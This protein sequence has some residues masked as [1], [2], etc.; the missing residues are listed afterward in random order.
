MV[1]RATG[2]YT[3]DEFSG[4]IRSVDVSRYG[5]VFVGSPSGNT[6]SELT[7]KKA[8]SLRNELNSNLLL[9][10]VLIPE[11]HAKKNEEHLRMLSKI[12]QGCSFFITQC[13]YNVDAAKDLLSDYHYECERQGVDK[14]PVI[15]T[16]TTCGSQQ[17]LS[18]MKW[19]GI[20]IPRW[21][22]N[23]LIHS[24]NILE[25]SVELCESIATELADFCAEK[26][27]PFGINVES[28][29]IRKAE[30][31]ASVELVHR[32]AGLLRE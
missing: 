11:R 8:Y 4:W 10:G 19:L 22:E 9:G 12:D 3:V 24:H 17:T 28:V 21:L 7:L 2:K 1:Y 20:T 25:K 32:M 13:V 18:F 27:I 29:S 16:L 5:S 23:D 6:I 15:F 14:V 30:I 26:K 31:D